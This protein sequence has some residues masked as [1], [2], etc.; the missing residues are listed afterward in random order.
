MR[1]AKRRQSHWHFISALHALGELLRMSGVR[2]ESVKVNK[3]SE[4]SERVVV[5][6]PGLGA[7][8]L[9]G[10]T[11][12]H[13]N[14]GA[15]LLL[16]GQDLPRESL[17]YMLLTEAKEGLLYYFPKHSL[18]ISADHRDRA[19]DMGVLGGCCIEVKDETVRNEEEFDRILRD[20]RW[21]FY[22]EK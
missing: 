12:L 14:L 20:A 1:A 3:L 2:F 22:G 6:C 10:D 9:V 16:K 11:K 15:L 5:N 21:F 4:L 18:T 13:P 8:E 17:Q 7:R 19:G